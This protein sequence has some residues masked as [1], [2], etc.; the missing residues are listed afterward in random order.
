VF[1]YYFDRDSPF[2]QFIEMP[3]RIKPDIVPPL[4]AVAVLN[5]YDLPYLVFYKQD[6]SYEQPT[7][8]PNVEKYVHKIL[9]DSAIIMDDQ[10]LTAYRVP[11]LTQT[12]P[13]IWP[14]NGWYPAEN[15]GNDT[16]RWSSG[17]ANIHINSKE[18]ISLHPTF[19]SS[20]FRGEGT[21]TVTVDDKPLKTFKLTNAFAD[22]D[23]GA[24]DLPPGE[25]TIVFSSD[26]QPVTPAS[27]GGAQDDQRQLAF[28]VKNLKLGV[29]TGDR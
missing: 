3:T 29:V 15:T 25:H 26:N 18:S 11:V 4:S 14:G 27:V 28:V 19:T 12:T 23:L 21:L 1:D 16:W 7:D 2:Y 8:K 22:L 20:T 10:Q 5:Y 13:L 6:E 9:P 24:I 17:R